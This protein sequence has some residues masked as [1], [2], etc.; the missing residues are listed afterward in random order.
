MAIIQAQI[1]KFKNLGIGKKT[2][3]NVVVTQALIDVT[4]K[5]MEQLVINKIKL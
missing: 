1:R 4:K 2:E 5:R 3:N